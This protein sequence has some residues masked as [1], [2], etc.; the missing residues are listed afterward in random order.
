[1]TN[2]V[3]SPKSF[4]EFVEMVLN[5]E[6]HFWSKQTNEFLNA[7]LD[8]SKA[9]IKII[10]P[11]EEYFRARPCNKDKKTLAKEEMK[12]KKDLRSEG[13]IN[14][15]NINVLYLANR[16]ETAI[17]ETRAAKKQ[18]ITVARFITNRELKV[19]DCTFD[20]PSWANWF[21][22]HRPKNQEEAEKFTWIAIGGAFSKPADDENQRHF[23]T[24]TQIIAEF[25]K[26]N[27]FDG[28]TYQSQ[29]NARSKGQDKFSGIS[30]NIAL[31]NINDADPIDAEQWKIN[32]KIIVASRINDNT[33]TY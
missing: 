15:Y 32:D 18:P 14:P 3:F 12:P 25:F 28:I 21:F 23:Y 9:R 33:T 13:R 10:P 7:L 30:Q 26:H 24:P 1:M 5:E 31:F 16:K 6:R 27:G 4:S 8:S 29:F 2:F 11:G 20:R 17:A 22:S 19:I